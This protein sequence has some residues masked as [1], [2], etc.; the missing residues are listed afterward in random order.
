M[1]VY[2]FV[3]IVSGTLNIFI[4]IAFDFSLIIALEKVPRSGF[5]GSK[6]FKV[7]MA[8]ASCAILLLRRLVL[9]SIARKVALL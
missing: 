9:V 3:I 6:G 1:G 8:L 4:L 7:F 2:I 5:T